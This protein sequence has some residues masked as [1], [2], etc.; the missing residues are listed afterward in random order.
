M[1]KSINEAANKRFYRIPDGETA[2]S[3]GEQF[4]ILVEHFTFLTHCGKN[5]DYGG[6]YKHQFTS[7]R[8]NLGK[9][10]ELVLQLLNGVITPE[11][12][13]RMS[14]AEMASEEQR[15]KDAL[16]KEENDKQAMA[17]KDDQ[18]RIR[19]THKGEEI[20]ISDHHVADSTPNSAAQP[21]YAERPGTNDGETGA[22]ERSESAPYVGQPQQSPRAS[23]PPSATSKTGFKIDRLLRLEG[24][25]SPPFSPY[26]PTSSEVVWRGK[27][28]MP[29]N[30]PGTSFFIARATHVAG[31]D[32]GSPEAHAAIFPENLVMDGRIEPSLADKYLSSLSIS[33]STDV[34]V[35]RLDPTSDS[36]DGND[37]FVG[38]YDYLKVRKDRYGVVSHVPRQP[39]VS[40][41]YLV[42]LAGG[43]SEWPTFLSMLVNN[44]V[45]KLPFE[46]ILLAVFV[47]RHKSSSIS[48]KA[49]AYPP[50]APPPS[51]TTPTAP[52]GQGAIPVR[53]SPPTPIATQG[54][55]A[56]PQFPEPS[57]T[58]QAPHQQ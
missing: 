11:A 48:T 1:V 10:M 2:G 18:L 33:Q 29:F 7:V 51:A 9:N 21:Q 15:R 16:L 46:R 43:K 47:I 22:H 12:L 5:P 23:E 17:I 37:E 36:A 58:E 44:E 42:P 45:Q 39:H 57:N 31:A 32:L 41:L 6:P 25:Q 34:V 28:E 52:H 53:P 38:L 49:G 4:G 50:G 3:L 40:D 27:V 13:S 35:Y 54:S 8:F 19:K 30:R 56:A 55:P 24:F 26:E 14:A 20:V